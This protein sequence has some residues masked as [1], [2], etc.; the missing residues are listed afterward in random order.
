MVR[1]LLRALLILTTI[2][3]VVVHEFGHQ[4]MCWLTGT[5]VR[6]VCYFRFDLP[7][8][9][10]LHDRPDRAWKH[11]LIA[12]G[13]LFLCTAAGIGLGFLALQG[14]TWIHDRLTTRILLTWLALAVAYQAFPSLGDASSVM[15]GIWRKGT[16]WITRLL[17]TPPAAALYLLAFA[18]RIWL[19]V[20]WALAA[21]WWAPHL[22]AGRRPW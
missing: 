3:G 4:V 14:H 15:E 7:P 10:V 2:P 5:R 9:Y 6:E 18:G 19:D 11:L 20:L 1:L 16:G 17:A 12:L 22:L 13:P 8:G 21:A